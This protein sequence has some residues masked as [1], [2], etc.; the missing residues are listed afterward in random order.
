MKQKG[1]LNKITQIISIS[2][3]YLSHRKNLTRVKGLVDH[4]SPKRNID[5]E[6]YL[7]RKGSYREA[8][9]SLQAQHITRQN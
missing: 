7:E 8:N 9:K 1:G 4:S 3:N 2:N 5:I 6:Q